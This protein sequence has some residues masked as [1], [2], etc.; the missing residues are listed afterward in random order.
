MDFKTS[1]DITGMLDPKTGPITTPN[2]TQTPTMKPT[3]QLMLVSGNRLA[4]KSTATSH[5]HW[6]RGF[7]SSGFPIFFYLSFFKLRIIS[8]HYECCRRVCRSPDS[9]PWSD[10]PQISLTHSPTP[11]KCSTRAIMALINNLGIV[12]HQYCSSLY[13]SP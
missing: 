1:F 8:P 9:W 10:Q 4:P 6:P 7:P 5:N 12:Y 2:I 3:G 11:P 13:I